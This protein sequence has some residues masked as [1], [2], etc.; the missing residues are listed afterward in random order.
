MNL[1]HKYIVSLYWESLKT[2]LVMASMV[3]LLKEPTQNSV[4]PIVE[5]KNMPCILARFSVSSLTQCILAH[6]MYPRSQ[7]IFPI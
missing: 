5:D 2:L 3:E 6:A 1:N 4:W 7:P